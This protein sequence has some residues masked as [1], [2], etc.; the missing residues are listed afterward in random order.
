MLGVCLVPEDEEHLQQ[1]P[2]PE[3]ATENR[4]DEE[5]RNSRIV[6]Y[7]HHELQEK[8]DKTNKSRE[9]CKIRIKTTEKPR[10]GQGI[11][12]SC[13]GLEQKSRHTKSELFRLLWR[14]NRLICPRVYDRPN[15][16]GLRGC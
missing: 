13:Q 12:N 1:F 14:F 16:E 8:L 10:L 7:V 3:R 11:L 9:S 5:A 4:S 15:S 2:V 6:Q